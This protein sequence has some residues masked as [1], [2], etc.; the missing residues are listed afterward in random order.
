MK[1]WLFMNVYPTTPL[2]FRR[3]WPHRHGVG[4]PLVDDLGVPQGRGYPGYLHF[5]ATRCR[6]VL[7]SWS[8]LCKNPP[9]KPGSDLNLF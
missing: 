6:T 4:S 5:H 3:V 9:G 8:S 1:Q 7:K 2:L